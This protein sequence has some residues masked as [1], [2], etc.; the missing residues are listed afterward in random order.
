MCYSSCSNFPCY[1]YARCCR[2]AD[3]RRTQE[4]T[5]LGGEVLPWRRRQ[6]SNLSDFDLVYQ[7]SLGAASYIRRRFWASI[8]RNWL[9]TDHYE[10]YSMRIYHVFKCRHGGNNTVRAST[11][12]SDTDAR[13]SAKKLNYIWQKH[14]HPQRQPIYRVAQFS[15]Q[16][17][18]SGK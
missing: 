7:S 5:G 13:Q 2:Q 1:S 16:P 3:D 9:S 18:R 10:L 12:D 17:M 15:I 14:L 8:G 6:V 11:R 4:S